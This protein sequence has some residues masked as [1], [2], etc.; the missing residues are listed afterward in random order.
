MKIVFARHRF[1]ASDGMAQL[2][3]GRELA[4]QGHTVWLYSKYPVV[5][6][7]GKA[8]VRRFPVLY[9]LFVCLFLLLDRP[10]FVMSFTEYFPRFFRSLGV[11][12]LVRTFFPGDGREGPIQGETAYK[13]KLK[14]WG[15]KLDEYFAYHAKLWNKGVDPAAQR[16]PY[17]H[18]FYAL[19]ARDF[20]PAAVEAGYPR[21]RL[22]VL[23]T[24][25]DPQAFTPATAPAPREGFVA[26]FMGL[27]PVRKG[28][29]YALKAFESVHARHPETRLLVVS[30]DLASLDVDGATLVNDVDYSQVSRIPGYLRQLDVLLLP[31]LQD[32]AP[33][34]VLEA[35][36][37]GVP[38][39]LSKGIGYDG[40]IVDG[41]NG[42]LVD[43]KDV[44]AIT[45]CIERLMTDS[46][47]R[48]SMAK[49]ARASAEQRSWAHAARAFAAEAE[50]VK[51]RP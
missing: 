48:A 41:V 46:A 35:M 22:L 6:A 9:N 32:G 10:Y 24:G 16:P 36:A 15:D 11:R 20:I 29:V 47:L 12:H 30:Y 25:I 28:L 1:K 5:G 38:V 39:I 27:D 37:S 8:R 18:S 44:K 45:A 4:D 21:D 14:T 19:T 23:E 2:A 40:F 7:T 13:F 33:V 43:K 3:V 26:G 50:R 34:Q 31:A 17:P 49:N 42:F 51:R